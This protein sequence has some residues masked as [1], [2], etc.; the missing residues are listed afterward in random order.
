M[1]KEIISILF[2]KFKCLLHAD[3]NSIKRILPSKNA[4]C[5]TDITILI[6]FIIILLPGMSFKKNENNDCIAKYETPT[7]KA[8][9]APVLCTPSCVPT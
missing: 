3:I 6:I 1:G 4:N 7:P 9:T 5:K 2:N 8:N